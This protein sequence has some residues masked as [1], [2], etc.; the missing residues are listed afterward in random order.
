[1]FFKVKSIQSVLFEGLETSKI[2]TEV[3]VSLRRDYPHQ[4][5]KKNQWALLVLSSRL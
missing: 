1:M 4:R 3:P 5:G 2:G